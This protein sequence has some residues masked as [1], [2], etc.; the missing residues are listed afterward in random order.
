[1]QQLTVSNVSEWDLLLQQVALKEYENIQGVGAPFVLDPFLFFDGTAPSH[2]DECYQAVVRLATIDHFVES[3]RLLP[4]EAVQLHNGTYK[5]GHFPMHVDGPFYQRND[6]YRYTTIDMDMVSPDEF[7]DLLCR[8]DVYVQ[9]KDATGFR[10]ESLGVDDGVLDMANRLN[11][12]LFVANMHLLTMYIPSEHGFTCNWD[13]TTDIQEEFD[14]VCDGDGDVLAETYEVQ[15]FRAEGSM[16][17]GIPC[18]IH[19]Q[20]AYKGGGFTCIS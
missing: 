13:T 8:H 9:V 5:G 18:Y 6:Q 10:M 1:M 17:E 14:F 19:T 2:Y 15:R 20:H 3:G 4:D 7:L 11:E 12:F 16:F